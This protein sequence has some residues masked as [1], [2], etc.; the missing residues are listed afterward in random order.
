MSTKINSAII[1]QINPQ[2]DK[3]AKDLGAHNVFVLKDI[4]FPMSKSA[5]LISFIKNFTSTMT[6]I[7]SI[8]FLIYPGRKLATL[9]M[10]DAIQG[11][12]YGVGS[13][14]ACM[15]IL[16]TLSVNIIF[17]KIV[18]EEKNVF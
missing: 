13:V 16:I 6:T 4:I 9:E 2:V 10:F 7:G 12:D 15:I 18:S 8:I 11:G 14:I 5:F 3:A 17:S 1:S